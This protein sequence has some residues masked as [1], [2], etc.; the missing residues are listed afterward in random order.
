M[1]H[2]L[3]NG[4][5]LLKQNS[6]PAT[7]AEQHFTEALLS[8]L[9]EKNFADIS[10]RELAARAGYDR[11]TYYRHFSRKE[12]VLASYVATIFS[13]MAELILAAG[14]MSVRSGFTAYFTF[15]ER[16]ID[17]LRLLAKNDLLHFLADIDEDVLYTF[18]GQAV[19]PDLPESLNESSD[20]SRYSYFFTTGGLRNVLIEWA[21][22]PD[23]TRTSPEQVTEHLIGCLSGLAWFIEAE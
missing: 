6:K 4:D 15:W 8:L 5:G 11:K 22:E 10:I 17:F 21:T 23:E 9:Q 3:R 14:P 18:V 16:H 7:L 19:Q 2:F 13:E 1:G 12:D 20:L